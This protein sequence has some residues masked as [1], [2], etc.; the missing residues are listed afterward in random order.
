MDGNKEVTLSV[1]ANEAQ[2]LLRVLG[3][4]PTKSGAFPLAA[5]IE[6]QANAQLAQAPAPVDGGLKAGGTD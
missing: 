1:T 4:L 6:K 3:E 5:K 2:F